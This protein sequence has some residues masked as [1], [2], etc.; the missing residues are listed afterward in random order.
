[1]LQNSHVPG[2]CLSKIPSLNQK[3]CC[4]VCDSPNDGTLGVLAVELLV[5]KHAV[6]PNTDF[7]QFTEPF[8]HRPVSFNSGVRCVACRRRHVECSINTAWSN[9]TV[10]QCVMQA[11]TGVSCFNT[12]YSILQIETST[13]VQASTSL[14]DQRQNSPRRKM[15]II[16]RILSC[17][18]S[19]Q[20]ASQR[21]SEFVS[22]GTS[23]GIC[24]SSQQGL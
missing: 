9:S 17:A 15:P 11:T 1:M 7:N 18:N 10:C 16:C 22:E 23:E 13:A 5:Q 14:R 6:L 20:N 2:P 24:L 12:D 3:R 19:G 8:L 4:G 21:T